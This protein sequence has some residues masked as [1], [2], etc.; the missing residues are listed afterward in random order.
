MELKPCPFCGGQAKLDELCRGYVFVAC[1]S[2][3][4][5]SDIVA[6]DEE[7]AEKWNRCAV[8]PNDPLTL[9]ELRQ[10]DGEPVWIKGPV[11]PDKGR[12]VILGEYYEPLHILNVQPRGFLD[13]K[14]INIRW[15]AYHRRP[16]EVE[17]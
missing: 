6:T 10:M 12:W 7:A 3:N 16:E 9:D 4:A 8:P 15:E 11:H 2:C 14:D 5:S 17:K 13:C 1:E